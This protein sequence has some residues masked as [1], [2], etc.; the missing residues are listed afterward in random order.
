MI[1]TTDGHTIE[2]KPG[3]ANVPPC[4]KGGQV[5]GRADWLL[6]DGVDWYSH[7]YR[8]GS[9]LRNIVY[10]AEVFTLAEWLECVDDDLEIWYSDITIGVDNVRT[11]EESQAYLKTIPA[12]AHLFQQSTSYIP[13][14]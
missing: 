4:I 1:K 6:I 14:L 13:T 7:S 8:N 3:A 5:V 10:A 12:F 2:I 11:A 9:I